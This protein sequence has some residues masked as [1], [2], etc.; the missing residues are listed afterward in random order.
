MRD[1]REVG[2]KNLAHPELRDGEM[3]LMNVRENEW[4]DVAYVTRRRGEK[5]FD[6]NGKLIDDVVAYSVFIQ[7]YEYRNEGRA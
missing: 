5:A 7:K 1:V 4:P 6:R 3:F 2:K